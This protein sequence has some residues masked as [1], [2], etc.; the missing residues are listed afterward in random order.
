MQFQCGVEVGIADLI[1]SPEPLGGSW[2]L[3]TCRAVTS[4]PPALLI[5]TAGLEPVVIVGLREAGGQVVLLPHGA[6]DPLR[7]EIAARLMGGAD[8]H[9]L[10]RYSA[11]IT[12]ELAGAAILGVADA[13]GSPLPDAGALGWLTAWVDAVARRHPHAPTVRT[14]ASPKVL[15]RDMPTTT[16]SCARITS[17]TGRTYVGVYYAPASGGL[18]REPE[19]GFGYEVPT[20]A[21]PI[22]GA[23]TVSDVAYKISRDEL[24]DRRRLPRIDK[25]A[26]GYVPFRHGAAGDADPTAS[27]STTAEDFDAAWTI[28][29]FTHLLRE[30]QEGQRAASR[31]LFL[32]GGPETSPPTVVRKRRRRE[33][34]ATD[35]VLLAAVR[36]FLQGIGRKDLS[37]LTTQEAE[38][39][40]ARAAEL[41]GAGA[42][43]HEHLGP[44]LDVHA[45]QSTLQVTTRQAVYDLVKRRRLL[46]LKREGGG[47]AFPAFQF[48]PATGR[49]Y[50]AVPM[51]IEIFSAN[52]VDGYTAASW[53]A[54]AQDDLAGALPRD[55]LGHEDQRASLLVA[56]RRAASRWSQ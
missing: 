30:A 32:A 40:G 16:D 14:A 36:G 50:P 44:L 31:S 54:T 34:S 4:G 21:D 47:M 27:S 2:V 23:P 33:A 17:T 22:W 38:E 20:L 37:D 19:P 52:G 9:L 6:G 11:P 51:L 49:P 43:W 39:L 18:L 12:A 42:A 28:S 1:E 3:H 5:L 53:L 24:T 48:D 8:S 29:V 10:N 7:T 13:M 41:V 15:R 55:L 46:A 35:A 25:I 56:A 45:V 26:P